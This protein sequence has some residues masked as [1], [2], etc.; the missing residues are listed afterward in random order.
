MQSTEEKFFVRSDRNNSPF[1]VHHVNI[2][3]IQGVSKKKLLKRKFQKKKSMMLFT[4]LGYNTLILIIYN[5]CSKCESLHV[6]E[7]LIKFLNI[8]HKVGTAID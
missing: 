7:C 6:R 8:L 4:M 5:R 1:I 2:I 3:L